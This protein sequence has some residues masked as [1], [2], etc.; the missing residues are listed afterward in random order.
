MH[1]FYGYIYFLNTAKNEQ[2]RPALNWI[3]HIYSMVGGFAAS[4]F[5]I[6]RMNRFQLC[7]F[8][9]YIVCVSK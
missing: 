8:F 2:Y 7:K 9:I 6:Q 4:A 1:T 3:V 5:F